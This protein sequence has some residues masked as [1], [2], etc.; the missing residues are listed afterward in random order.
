MSLTSDLLTVTEYALA[1]LDPLWGLAPAVLAE[2]LMDVLPGTVDEW[3]LAA[4]AVAADYYDDLRESA[5]VAGTFTAIIEPLE[6]LGVEALAGWAADALRKD[7]PDLTAARA[8]VEGGMQKRM[9]NTANRTVTHSATEDP[10]ARGYMRRTR[11]NAC[12]FCKMVASRGGVYTRASAT[13]ACHEQ[14][15]CEA[16]PAWGGQAR[17][18]GPYKPSDRPNND[19]ERARVK[20]WIAAN[21]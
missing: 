21:L 2:A 10:N 11:P 17:P 6:G 1:E 12:R 13:F 9:V 7:V 3:S 18:V 8:R 16:V 15:F 5:E 19:E 14:C 4:A 20:A